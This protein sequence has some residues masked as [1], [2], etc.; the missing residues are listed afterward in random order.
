[1][2][3]RVRLLCEVHQRAHDE[4]HSPGNKAQLHH[5]V[6]RGGE[7]EEGL[8]AKG[9]AVSLVGH[10]LVHERVAVIEGEPDQRKGGG[11]HAV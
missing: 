4:A 11:E 7:S 5:K 9:S 6:E 1:M 8:V 3:V 2:R 10:N